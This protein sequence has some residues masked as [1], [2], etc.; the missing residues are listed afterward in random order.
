MIHILALV[1][2]SFHMGMLSK[3][4]SVK[5]L[6]WYSCQ[7]SC[8]S[9]ERCCVLE[10]ALCHSKPLLGCFARWP[11]WNGCRWFSILWRHSRT[12]Q[13][14]W[15]LHATCLGQSPVDSFPTLVHL[16]WIWIFG[17]AVFRYVT[18]A[19]IRQVPV[20]EAA[21]AAPFASSRWFFRGLALSYSL[22]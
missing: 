8:N 22:G 17:F 15:R 13:T 16:F 12:S 20:T 3:L 6:C 21:C 19:V 10:N 1:H 5:G 7:T 18:A 11:V 2:L 9:W 4:S 14:I